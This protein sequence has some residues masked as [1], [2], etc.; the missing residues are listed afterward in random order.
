MTNYVFDTSALIGL[1]RGN[2]AVVE[3]CGELVK[4][5][6]S[7]YTTTLNAAEFYYG[8]AA[9]NKEAKKTAAEFIEQFKLLTLTLDSA[10]NY[11]ELAYLHDQAGEKIQDFDLLTAVIAMDNNAIIITLDKGFDRIMGAKTLLLQQHIPKA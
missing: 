11:A 2:K 1:E 5:E 10:R 9:K 8:Y 7:F 6:N 4:D 3:Q